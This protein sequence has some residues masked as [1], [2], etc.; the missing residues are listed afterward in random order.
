MNSNN[1]IDEH[2][3]QVLEQLWSHRL[4]EKL[5]NIFLFHDK[6]AGND[7]KVKGKIKKGSFNEVLLNIQVFENING[8]RKYGFSVPLEDYFFKNNGSFN[9]ANKIKSYDLID[10]ALLSTQHKFLNNIYRQTKATTIIKNRL[11]YPGEKYRDGIRSLSYEI[12]KPRTKSHKAVLGSY[13]KN[14]EYKRFLKAYINI[15]SLPEYDFSKIFDDSFPT[16]TQILF[17]RMDKVIDKFNA[18]LAK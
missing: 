10:S 14:D 7:L 12:W 15:D 1:G 9:D 2:T 4:P 17:S 5:P 3:K 18:Y 13:F 16:E 8:V 6:F 11:I